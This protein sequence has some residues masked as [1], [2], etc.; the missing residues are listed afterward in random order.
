MYSIAIPPATQL[1]HLGAVPNSQLRYKL[2][3]KA[4][5]FL[6]A[7][8]LRGDANKQV[9]LGWMEPP[10][11]IDLEGSVDNY[12]EGAVNIAFLPFRRGAGWK[13]PGRR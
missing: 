1:P 12:V 5:G 9:K 4:S 13:T 6:N 8:A 7:E 10:L 3:S 2:R 11:P